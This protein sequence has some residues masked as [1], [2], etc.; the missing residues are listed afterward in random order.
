MLQV[1]DPV[2]LP[3]EL[4]ERGTAGIQQGWQTGDD[5]WPG[6]GRPR[7]PGHLAE[8]MVHLQLFLQLVNLVVGQLQHVGLE[9][10]AAQGAE[11]H[12]E[13]LLL[14]GVGRDPVCRQGIQSDNSVLRKMDQASGIRSQ[15]QPP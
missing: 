12:V 8:G 10:T 14:G 9:P 4:S 3:T 15:D 2:S 11:G 13:P 1:T 6:Q 5:Y 7:C